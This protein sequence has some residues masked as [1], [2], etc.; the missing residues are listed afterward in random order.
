MRQ[1]ETGPVLKVRA[2]AGLHV[3][4][5]AWDFVLAPHLGP[6]VLP[7]PPHP[8]LGF[9]IEREELGADGEVLGRYMLRGTRRFESKD[10]GLPAGTPVPLDEH[11]IQSFVW[12]DHTVRPATRYAYRVI[13]VHGTPKNLTVRT[14]DSTRIPI[15][16]EAEADP[17]VLPGA[18]RHD[19]FVSR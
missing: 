16:T 19:L 1:I 3:V 15:E 9:A 17:S 12:A 10:P 4:V 8:L 7:A 11:P 6:G 5:L 18:P 2:V 13:P 14:S